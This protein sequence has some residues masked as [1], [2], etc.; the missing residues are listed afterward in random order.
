MIEKQVAQY[1]ANVLHDLMGPK[2]EAE[3]AKRATTERKAGNTEE[4]RNWDQIRAILRER[5]APVQG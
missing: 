4:A 1:Q 3:A 5:R 2:A